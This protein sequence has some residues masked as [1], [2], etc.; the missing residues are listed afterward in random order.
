[1]EIKIIKD[2]DGKTHYVPEEPAA[3]KTIKPFLRYLSKKLWWKGLYGLSSEEREVWISLW[4]NADAEGLCW[5]SQGGLALRL[6]RNE[7]TIKK[8]LKGLEKK[9]FIKRVFRSG[10]RYLTYL[11]IIW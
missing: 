7:N 4:L 11:K 6:P 10:N 9:G 1:M 5:T 8:A 3:A 2:K